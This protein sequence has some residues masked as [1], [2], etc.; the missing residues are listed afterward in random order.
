MLLQLIAYDYRKGNHQMLIRLIR[1]LGFGVC[2]SFLGCSS[3][4]FSQDKK[5]AG[6]ERDS[7][8]GESETADEPV[9]VGG[10]YL[11]C[12]IVGDAPA[13][14]SGANIGCAVQ[15]KS[16]DRKANMNGI[17]SSWSLVNE[18]GAPVSVPVVA[19]NPQDDYHKMFSYPDQSYKNH[20]LQLTV[21]D[22][23]NRQW[24]YKRSLSAMDPRV[25]TYFRA[26]ALFTPE[27]GSKDGSESSPGGL[28]CLL[29]QSGSCLKEAGDWTKYIVSKMNKGKKCSGGQ[30]QKRVVAEKFGPESIVILNNQTT[31]FNQESGHPCI[32]NQGNTK[33]SLEGG[34][35]I[36]PVNLGDGKY[37][38][39]FVSSQSGVSF[40]EIVAMSQRYQCIR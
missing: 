14:N 30:V 40:E 32:Y 7:G 2:L 10:A 17:S 20:N 15:L 23:S 39:Y 21:S 19:G 6:S 13:S 4:N 24:T 26:T 22:H 12:F 9:M 34:C 25:P 8:D 5:T 37:H 27:N 1:L 29:G 16:N 36:I 3:G 11:S 31:Y 28:E 33:P 38:E 18:N 35:F